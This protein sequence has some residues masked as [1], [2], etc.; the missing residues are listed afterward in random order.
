MREFIPLSYEYGEFEA[1]HELSPHDS[2]PIPREETIAQ[3]YGQFGDLNPT[4]NTTDDLKFY[5]L[6][7]LITDPTS[8]NA[9]CNTEFRVTIREFS[10]IEDLEKGILY[11]RPD[12]NRENYKSGVVWIYNPNVLA[13]SFKNAQYTKVWRI[14]H[15]LGH[16]IVEPFLHAR[17]GKSKRQGQ[18]GKR[19]R[20]IWRDDNGKESFVNLPPITVRQGQ[21]AIEWESLAFRAQRMIFQDDLGVRISDEEYQKEYNG[22]M[23]DAVFRVITGEFGEPGEYGLIPHSEDVALNSILSAVEDAARQIPNIHPRILVSPPNLT[24]W[25]PIDDDDIRKAI[26][27]CSREGISE[28]HNNWQKFDFYNVP[29]L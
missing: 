27:T 4:E 20:A 16:C 13:G 1:Y 26:E 10:Y 11:C 3:I 12:L 29:A 7:S 22:N 19:H 15:E 25:F 28:V 6:T 18:L 24:E 9:I 5:D 17:Y 23:S 14:V 21:R 8:L 2:K